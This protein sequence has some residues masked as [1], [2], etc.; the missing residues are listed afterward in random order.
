MLENKI[1]LVKKT[2]PAL[3]IALT[4]LTGTITPSFAHGFSGGH[5]FGGGHPS[6]HGFGGGRRFVG[7]WG[8]HW[9]GWGGY[10]IPSVVV[11]PPVV[12]HETIVQ[13]VPASTEPVAVSTP[14]SGQIVS[15]EDAAGNHHQARLKL[16]NDAAGH[17]VWLATPLENNDQLQLT[18][19]VR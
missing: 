9:G 7:G 19:K 11:T 2:M 3:M 15:I 12:E 6:F 5:G 8:H 1:Q 17:Q 4:T 10:W 18:S 13:M 14:E 16:T